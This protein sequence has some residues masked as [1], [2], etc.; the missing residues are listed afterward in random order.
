MSPITIAGKKKQQPRRKIKKTTPKKATGAALKSGRKQVTNP[1]TGRKILVG[2]PTYRKVFG[3]KSVHKGAKR[4]SPDASVPDILVNKIL[5][6][7]VATVEELQ[8]TLR[9]T[10]QPALRRKLEAQIAKSGDNRG[11]RTRGWS[12]RAPQ[13]GRPRE[14]L[15]KVCGDAAF[16]LPDEKKFPI[17]AKCGAGN[18]AAKCQCSIDCGGVLAALIRARQYGYSNIA[19][20]AKT[21]LDQKCRKTA[22]F[23]EQA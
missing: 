18:E 19:E 11:S 3:A 12:A 4:A 20:A 1:Q 9:R 13:R 15:Q 17:M 10:T 6:Q 22:E 8:D 7:K 14:T 16:L 2:G 23:A 21:I 5:A